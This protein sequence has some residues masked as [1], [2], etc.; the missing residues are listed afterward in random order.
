MSSF[1]TK[2]LK[3]SLFGESHASA[4]GIV[5]DGLPAGLEIDLDLVEQEMAR[6]R[7]QSGLS[8]ARREAD[9]PRIL[10]GFYQ[11]R[12]T[13]TPLA[14]VIE[15]QNTRSQDYSSL[16]DIPRPGHADYTGR[17]R[18]GGFNDPR[19][20]GHFSGR[21]T[22]PLVFAGSLAKQFLALQGVA[23]GAHICNIGSVRDDRFDPVALSPDLFDSLRDELPF[24]DSEKKEAA[25]AV[26]EKAA[27]EGDS[28]GG[29]IECAVTGLKAGLGNPFFDSVESQIASL[30]FSIPAVKG[31]EFGAGFSFCEMNG[32]RANDPFAFDENGKVITLTNHNGGLLGGITSGMPLIFRVAVKPTASIFQEQRSVSLSGKTETPLTVHGRHDPC[33]VPRAVPVVEA[34]AALAVADLLLASPGTVSEIN[35]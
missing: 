13:G 8:T 14:A 19:G 10:C 28:V 29:S 27:S 16:Q 21:L 32:S 2:N 15:N 22:A 4:V 34:A 7:P 18:Y 33:I 9:I 24:L 1:W 12:T 26:A 6:R 5:I 11:G 20:G 23:V 3:L 25:R 30:M 17:V 31:I 35:K